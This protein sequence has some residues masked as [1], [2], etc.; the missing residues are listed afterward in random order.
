[1]NDD[2]VKEHSGS[3]QNLE[4][5]PPEAREALDI[6]M[7]EPQQRWSAHPNFQEVLMSRRSLLQGGVALAVTGI[8]ASGS[9]RVRRY[10]GREKLA[11]ALAALLDDEIK[12]VAR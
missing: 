10:V 9:S 5:T 2:Y 8:L 4:T 3:I 1:M 6:N 11:T 12:A 7:D